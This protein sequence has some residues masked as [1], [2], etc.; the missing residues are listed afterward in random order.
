MKGQNENVA[1]VCQNGRSRRDIPMA[2]CQNRW[3][4]G[5]LLKLVLPRFMDSTPSYGPKH[6]GPPSTE[7]GIK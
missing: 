3:D 6:K 5:F 1:S 7:K 2:P 4:F